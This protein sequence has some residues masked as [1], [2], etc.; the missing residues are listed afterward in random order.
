MISKRVPTGLSRKTRKTREL[1]T[2]ET[3]AERVRRGHNRASAEPLRGSA[4][5]KEEGSRDHK[6]NV[7]YG[8]SSVLHRGRD[9]RADAQFRASAVVLRDRPPRDGSRFAGKD[10]LRTGSV[11]Q[12][13][14]V[15]H[16][17]EKFRR[18]TVW[19]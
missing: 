17:A 6:V 19:Q 7:R 5:H 13:D 10:C 11:L 15:V 8:D 12:E 1:Q 14:T 16:R 4:L 9:L 18:R 3:D 2:V